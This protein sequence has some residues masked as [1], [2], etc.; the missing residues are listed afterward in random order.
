MLL[1]VLNRSASGGY[2]P[3]EE[4]S[5]SSSHEEDMGREVG[6]EVASRG[7]EAH[8]HATESAE[9][10]PISDTDTKLESDDH[11][12]EEENVFFDRKE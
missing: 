11:P 9:S 8:G 7:A 3:S 6:E 1:S 2:Y 4:C 5:E 12:D 10:G